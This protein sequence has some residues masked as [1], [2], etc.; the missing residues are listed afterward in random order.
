MAKKINNTQNFNIDGSKNIQIGNVSINNNSEGGKPEEKS[1]ESNFKPSLDELPQR[2][3]QGDI[4][5]ALELL[6]A[7]TESG[8]QDRQGLITLLFQ[9]YQTLEDSYTK[10]VITE[11]TYFQQ[12]NSLVDD[13]LKLR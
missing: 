12:R 5:G 6:E 4:R 10:K 3:K 9:R 8:D 7:H 2:I 11:A 1:L 13:I